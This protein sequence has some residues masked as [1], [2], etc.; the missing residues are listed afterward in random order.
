MEPNRRFSILAFPQF[1][2]GN[3]L[4]LNIVVLPRNQNPL[5][6]AIEQHD[7]VTFPPPVI[8]DAPA[9]AD[10]NLSF[11][12]K[13]VTGLSVFPHNFLP[14]AT[15][16]LAAN[17]PAQ[18]R[19][20]FLALAK[21]F[22][23]SNLNQT[24]ENLDANVDNAQLPESKARAQDLSVKKY[25]PHSYRS[26]FNFTTPRTRNAVTDDSYQCAV[27]DATK[28]PGF[29]RSLDVISWGKVFAFALRQ[30]LLAE[31]LGM[32]Y[33]TTLAID[34][35][36]FPQGGWLFVDLGEQSDY[37]AQ[38]VA[39]DSFIKKYA[40]RIPPLKPNE[41]RQV[42]APLLYP[43]LYKANAADPDPLPDG[44]YD[45]IF[46]ESADYDDGFAK[47]VHAYQPHSRNLLSEESDGA[48][49]V[50]DAG[51]RLGWD[52]EQILIWYMRQL[53]IDPTV[54]SADKR[55]DAPLGVF[56]YAVDVRDTAN[57]ANAWDS[58]NG[59]NTKQ[60]LAVA[61][62]PAEPITFANANTNLE[63]PYQVYPLQLDGDKSKT[64]WLPMYFAQWNGHSMVLPD[65]DAAEIYQ[66]TN[67]NVKADPET[68]IPVAQQDPTDPEYPNKKTGTSASGPAKNQLN[69]MYAAAPINTA[70]RY[71][72]QYEFRIRLQDLSGGGPALD[73]NIQ[74]KNETP[75]TRGKCQFKRYVAPNQVR[76]ENLL[77]N[78]D[79]LP[80]PNALNVQRPL[81]GYPALVFTGKY[82]N[83]VQAL[84]DASLKVLEPDP[85]H[86][87]RHE[88]FGVADPDV[89]RVQI[90]VEV[91]TLRLDNLLSVSG[92]ENY[93]HLYTTTRKF[94]NVANE[95]DYDAVLNIPLIYRDCPVLHVGDEVDLTN[96]LQLPGDID[97]LAEIYLPTARA[98]RLTLRA[99][100][101]EKGDN[102]AY[103]GLLDNAN[104]EMDVRYGHIVETRVYQPST[105]E[106][107]LFVN[108]SDAQKLQG[109]YLQPDPPS[110][111]DGKLT[112]LLLGKQIDQAPGIMQRLAQQLDV[113]SIGLT[114][115][116]PKGE[117]VQFGCSNRIRHT[118]SPENSSITFASQGDLLNHWLCCIALDV[119]RD[120]TWDALQDR[121][122]VITRT[123]RFTR[124][125]VNT[126]T[127]TLQVGTVEVRHTASFEALQNPK[128]NFTR[129]IFIDAVEPKNPRTQ[130]PAGNPA[131]RFPD[132][133]EVSY[134]IHTEFKPQHA[135]QHDN[136][137]QVASTLPITIPPAQIPKIASAGIAL[138]PYQRNEKYSATEPRRRYLWI[139]FEEPIAD[140]NDTFFARVL[141]YA[142]D[143]LISNNQPELF[144]AP[145][146]PS[147]PIDPELIRVIPPGATNDLAGLNA[148]QPMQKALHGD[149][150]YL[151]PLPPGLHSDAAEMFGFFT[152]EL[153]V[154]HFRNAET[155]E[156]AWCTAQ[157]RFGR[158]L[159]AAGI[160]HPAPTLTCAV[161]R[162]ED[163]LYV[164]APY[165]VAVFNGKNVTAD[166]PRTQLWCLLYAQVKQADDADFRNIL[167]DDK[168]LD[169]RVKIEPD[170]EVNWFERYD[171]QQRLT[172][173]N[174][175]IKNW[176]DDLSYADFHH[177]YQLADSTQSNKDATKYGTTVWSNKEIEQLLALYGLPLDL[178][179]SVLV[180]EILPTIT[181]I[182]EH[183]SGLGQQHIHSAMSE[184]IR[185][186]DLP[187]AGQ[188]REQMTQRARVADFQQPPSPLGDEL[189]QHRIL[190]T[191]PLTQVPFVC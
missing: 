116:A 154:G 81:L 14:N 144:V 120:W 134:S 71:G 46:L 87:K 50:K 74:P 183:I 30:P 132:T 167:L 25:L 190:R 69:Q 42:F 160:Q 3:Q 10:A 151:L 29:Q 127:E 138:S 179:L 55:L 39:D 122:F 115:T 11:N 162:D 180:V 145:Q 80:A 75:S 94:P 139:E 22:Q 175:T 88:A 62:P 113:E 150:H 45:Q 40:A 54:T 37:K 178:P 5:K 177:V 121:S 189:G 140:P 51:V 102:N 4:A 169:W 53:M 114:L 112:T 32:L 90:V 123:T 52:D 159:R 47:I 185:M 82:A 28:A 24:N 26:A 76:V 100:C 101:E 135:A 97:D 143:Q 170:K 96:D 43:V 147:L 78:T 108:T 86:E 126:E 63:L 7:G 17:A 12:A 36:H 157:G 79:D 181:N 124:D 182:Y 165:A 73:P 136:D 33:H 84:K 21:N 27:R 48:H 187:S 172:L 104:Q 164:T 98:I 41:P 158:P 130:P 99:V 64:Y 163:K 156:M 106:T 58:L 142:P 191:S 118:L 49:P 6:P 16:A 153:R 168:P 125:D 70:L 59:V 2:D 93:V 184:S 34:A 13:I 44:N 111:F 19:D 161:N 15:L 103:Y 166:P 85:A 119:N 65:N 133:I 72:K 174:V 56:G 117:R 18:A 107:A 148:M 1:F 66:T 105:D 176:K 109:I 35:A 20:L 188:V 92:K 146:E 129:L 110:V 186:T 9:F 95:A 128:R 152:Y 61:N 149:K 155:Q 173:R 8:P 91:Q 77:V 31:Q 171:D 67:P 38:Q 131:L 57:A 60:N 83:P 23:I 68:T 89:D 141:A 137:V